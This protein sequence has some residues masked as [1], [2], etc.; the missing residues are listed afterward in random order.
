MSVFGKVLTAL[1]IVGGAAAAVFAVKKHN[2]LKDYDYEDLD[3]DFDESSCGCSC[4]EC[5]ESAEDSEDS[6]DKENSVETSDE[7]TDVDVEEELDKIEEPV[8]E[9]DK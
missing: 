7:N 6:E 3:E 4:D 9:V 2:E 1:G 8:E 5:G